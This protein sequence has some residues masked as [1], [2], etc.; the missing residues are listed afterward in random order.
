MEYVGRSLHG[1]YF[2]Y[3]WTSIIA[4]NAKSMLI[5]NSPIFWSQPSFS[6]EM[7]WVVHRCFVTM[8]S[9]RM[10][11]VH[12]H[13]AMIDFSSCT[14]LL[15]ANNLV[16]SFSSR[17]SV[18]TYHELCDLKKAIIQYHS[19][20][21]GSEGYYTYE[22]LSDQRLRMPIYDNILHCQFIVMPIYD[23]LHCHSIVMQ[24]IT[25]YMAPRA[26]MPNTGTV[27]T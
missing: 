21:V 3:I 12:V 20:N 27:V 16:H 19:W 17:V 25:Y 8:Y 23:I 18:F 13:S 22:A 7:N 11:G 10:L 1:F 15:W 26:H 2:N 14:L 9:H 5:I 4:E 24:Q 6:H